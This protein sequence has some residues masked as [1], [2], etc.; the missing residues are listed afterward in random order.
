MP[1]GCV[2]MVLSVVDGCRRPHERSF[3][4]AAAVEMD[5]EKN[6]VTEAP[7]TLLIEGRSNYAKAKSR[8]YCYRDR[9]IARAI[10]TRGCDRS[11]CR[12]PLIRASS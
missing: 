9:Y 3:F 8:S 2:A 4:G 11:L 5:R 7:H 12:C 10:C 1:A 6:A